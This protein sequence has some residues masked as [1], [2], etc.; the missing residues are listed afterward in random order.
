[1]SLEAW[2]LFVLTETVLCLTPGP[3]V[4]F[5]VSHALSRGVASSV[6]GANGILTANVLYFALSATGFG[7]VLLEPASRSPRQIGATRA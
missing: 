7:A 4:L 1:M 5:V 3:A 2:G 6:A